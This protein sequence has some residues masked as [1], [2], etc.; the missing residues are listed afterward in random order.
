MLI[1]RYEMI[2]SADDRCDDC[3]RREGCVFLDSLRDEVEEALALV[4]RESD[5]GIDILV[6]R[7][8]FWLAEV[9]T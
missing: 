1:T 6:R 8:R 4:G 7:C 2:I 3:R 5:E 9:N